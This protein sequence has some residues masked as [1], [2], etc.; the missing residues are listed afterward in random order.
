[1]L[2]V[3]KEFKDLLDL[4][5]KDRE[6]LKALQGQILELQKVG[7]VREERIEALR[8]HNAALLIQKENL[9]K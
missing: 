3:N 6:K 9:L 4:D 7:K 2:K 8:P 1:M 5:K